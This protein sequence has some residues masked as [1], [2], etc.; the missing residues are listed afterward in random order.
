MHTQLLNSILLFCVIWTISH[1][2]GI[3]HFGSECCRC[4]AN[5]N[6][7][8]RPRSRELSAHLSPTTI[9]IY[10]MH[11]KQLGNCGLNLNV[12]NC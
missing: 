7:G 1:S 3:N 12:E 2:S 5:L 4:Y 9:A 8:L 10:A 6:P 11:V